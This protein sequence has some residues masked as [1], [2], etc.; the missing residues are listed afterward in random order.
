MA[1]IDRQR[2]TLKVLTW[3]SQGK[4]EDTL[5]AYIADLTPDVVC[6]QECGALGGGGP[7]AQTATQGLANGYELAVHT[8]DR[9]GGMG[10]GNIRCSLAM[11]YT[12]D[13]QIGETT[14]SNDDQKRPVMHVT[15]GDTGTRVYNIHAGG[16]AYIREVLGIAS[17]G[18]GKF[19]IAGDF[20]QEPH[21]IAEYTDG[22]YTVSTAPAWTRPLSHR[23]LDYGVSTHPGVAEIAAKE[24]GASD[25]LP[26]LLTFKLAPEPV[27]A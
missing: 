21:D 23:V 10:G 6:V 24:Y 22:L 12:Q 15:H 18:G 11:L 2:G 13:Y 8:W 4:M 17:V 7:L 27:Y 26:V 3:N 20:N 9:S 14:L 16:K 19:V 1:A 5:M 25:H